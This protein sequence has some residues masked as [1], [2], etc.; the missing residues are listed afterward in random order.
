MSDILIARKLANFHRKQEYYKNE[1][2]R[3]KQ[4]LEQQ[5]RNMIA[6]S[7]LSDSTAAE[8]LHNTNSIKPDLT[9]ATHNVKNLQ[10]DYLAPIQK[11]FYKYPNATESISTNIILTPS[12][13]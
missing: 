5:D 8:H 12:K 6:I 4:L 9:N 11:S 3:R 13:G 10:K 1:D 2:I 7:M